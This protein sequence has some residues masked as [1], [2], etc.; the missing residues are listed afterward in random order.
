MYVNYMPMLTG[1]YRSLRYRTLVPLTI[2][3]V[4]GLYQDIGIFFRNYKKF[5]VIINDINCDGEFKTLV[6][7]VNDK[8]NITMKYISKGEHVPEVELNNRSIGECIR[9]TYH[10]LPYNII[11][12]IMLKYL[13]MIFTEQWNIFPN[14]SVL[15]K[16]F[17]PH[18]I[19]T[20][21]DLD[22]GKHCQVPF[23]DFVQVNQENNR[24][25]TNAPQTIDVI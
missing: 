16:Y 8:L 6:D 13:T 10:N 24:T 15:S 18:V 25:Y 11:P 21:H 17:I 2:R 1:I 22:F 3:V 9:A 19:M 23:G 20:K 4:K 12:R 14:K 5:V 7:E